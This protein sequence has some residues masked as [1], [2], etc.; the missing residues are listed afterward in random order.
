[1]LDVP[2]AILSNLGLIYLAR[3][4]EGVPTIWQEE[5]IELEPLEW[6]VTTMACRS[7]SGPCPTGLPAAHGS[8]PG[9]ITTRLSTD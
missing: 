9:V 6:S 8:R 5:G 3:I 7:W 2:E 1:V 4:H